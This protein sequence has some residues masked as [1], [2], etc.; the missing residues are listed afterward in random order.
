MEAL[1]SQRASELICSAVTRSL[2]TGAG[3]QPM[4]PTKPPGITTREYSAGQQEHA[5]LS[6]FRSSMQNPTTL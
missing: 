3:R 6:Y 2:Q 5:L 1:R 4:F